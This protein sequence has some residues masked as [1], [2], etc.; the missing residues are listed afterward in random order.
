MIANFGILALFIIPA[1][2]LAFANLADRLP[3]ELKALVCSCFVLLMMYSLNYIMWYLEVSLALI[4]I[5]RHSKKMRR[6]ES[7]K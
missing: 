4:V 1:V 7:A 2:V 5:Y 6:K 3:L